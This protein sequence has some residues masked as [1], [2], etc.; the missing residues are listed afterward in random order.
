MKR[1]AI[2]G[3][4]ASGLACLKTILAYQD[5][6]NIIVFDRNASI[7]KK[8]AATGNGHC[9]LS[10][11]NL[12]INAYRGEVTDHIMNMIQS[13][14]IESFCFDLGFLTR[15]RGVLY[16]P[17]SEQAKTVVNAFEKMIDNQNIELHLN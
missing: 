16:Y 11:A 5:Q 7:G 15:K 4:G 9:N 10:N 1:L 13:F 14:D 8:I 17:Y 3:A 2:I 6:L 12:Y